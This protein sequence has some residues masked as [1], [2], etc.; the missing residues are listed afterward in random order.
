MSS[1]SSRPKAFLNRQANLRLA[2]LGY[3]EPMTRDAK[4]EAWWWLQTRW[5]AL[6]KQRRLVSGQ[7]L[8]WTAPG[9]VER[10]VDVPGP[11]LTR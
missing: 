7:A 2:Q 10:V 8:V 1:F 9:R 11:A 3:T 4:R 6:T 5:Q